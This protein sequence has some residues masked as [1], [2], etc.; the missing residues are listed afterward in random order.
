MTT[1]SPIDPSAPQS[2]ADEFMYRQALAAVQP[3]L[4]ALSPEQ[5]LPLN[6]DVLSVV[7]I[8]RGAIPESMTYRDRIS[9]PPGFDIAKVDKLETYALALGHAHTLQ[10]AT[11]SA[12]GARRGHADRADD[13]ARPHALGLAGARAAP[14]HRCGAAR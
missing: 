13:A 7:M 5:L 10:A 1:S 11:F 14:P 9:Q 12:D 8:V 6:L 4:A 3:E 2:P